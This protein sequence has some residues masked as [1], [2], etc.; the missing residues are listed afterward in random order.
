MGGEASSNQDSLMMREPSE[1]TGRWTVFAGKT[2]CT[3]AFTSDRIESANAWRVSDEARCLDGIAPRIVGW[4]PAPDGI[5]LVSAD[6]RT[7]VMFDAAGQGRSPQG[8]AIALRR[9]TD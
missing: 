7:V 1:L 6:R 4:R 2:I 5:E 3:L 8:E 9:A